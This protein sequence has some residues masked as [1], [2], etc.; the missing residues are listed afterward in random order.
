MFGAKAWRRYRRARA[1][2]AGERAVRTLRGRAAVREAE[3]LVEAAWIDKLDR[4]D[5][6]D[7]RVPHL[8]EREREAFEKAA[9]RRAAEAEADRL[10]LAAITEEIS[11]T[12][13]TV[14]PN[15]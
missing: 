6:A 11:E 9:R 5:R 7:P 8:L 10:R 4:A 12:I 3:G 1:R 15:R 13:R 14:P 2:A